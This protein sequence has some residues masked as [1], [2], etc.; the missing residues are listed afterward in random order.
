MNRFLLTISSI[1]LFSITTTAMGDSI[2]A[3][4]E[5]T[6]ITMSELMQRKKLLSYFNHVGNLSPEQDKLYTN[7]VLQSMI[8][9]QILLEYGK[10]VGLVVLPNEINGFLANIEQTA[11][12]KP[13]QLVHNVVHNL[14]LPEEEL[15]NKIK[16]EIIKSKVI[17]EAL[18]RSVKVSQEDIDSMVL[19]TNFRDA[20]LKL[21]IFTAKND[22]A[23]TA[24]SMAR[25]PS[26]IKN[27]SRI[28][29]VRYKR[30]ADL[31]E[32][33]V[34]LSQLSASMQAA[35]KDLELDEASDVIEEDKLRVVVVCAKSLNQF[36]LEDSNNIANF[37]G[38]KKL[39]IKAQKF[40]QD[41]RKKA[42][43]KILM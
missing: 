28:K 22:S 17:R 2:V 19:A 27:C 18:S 14:G 31:S 12:M 13:G 7:M 32:L 43:V 23:K 6:S 33:D 8:D 29:Y 11:K 16:S 4:I 34:N 9:D 30:F 39:Q 20:S 1:L 41:L 5:D 21:K 15:R 3:I 36:S 37:L 35:V 10:T 24:K 42:Y 38:N 26:Q 40:F 25:L